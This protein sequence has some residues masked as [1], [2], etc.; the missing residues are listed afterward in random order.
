MA[1]GFPLVAERCGAVTWRSLFFAEE[2]PA[3][4]VYH[5]LAGFE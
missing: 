5:S 1:M 3:A 2:S 4:T